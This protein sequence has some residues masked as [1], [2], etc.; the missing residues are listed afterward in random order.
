MNVYYDYAVN[1]GLSQEEAQDWADRL[2]ATSLSNEKYYAGNWIPREH[3]LNL[4]SIVNPSELS[5]S[6]GA[7]QIER[8]LLRRRPLL[9]TF[10]VRDA[11]FQHAS[12]VVVLNRLNLRAIVATGGGREL[13]RYLSQCNPVMDDLP[14][15]S[16]WVFEPLMSKSLWSPTFMETSS[17]I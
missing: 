11:E 9:T 12:A 4:L 3:L 6:G 14:T 7:L 16:M 10:T 5:A 17:V 2:N 1:E 15:A 8:G 13:F